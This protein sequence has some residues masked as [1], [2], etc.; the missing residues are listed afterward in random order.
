MRIIYKDDNATQRERERW[1]GEKEGVRADLY[2][3]ERYNLR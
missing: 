3:K 1:F 2:I